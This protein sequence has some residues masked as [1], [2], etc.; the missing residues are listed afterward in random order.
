MSKP[1]FV[2]TSYIRSTPEQV[3]KGLTSPEFQKQYW[4]L[5]LETDWV[6]GSEVVWVWDDARV[7]SPTQRV[8]ECDPYSRLSYS[9]H[10]IDEQ[11]D[12][13]MFTAEEREHMSTE[14]ASRATF[15]L[16]PQSNG[17][18]KLT[19]T[20]DEFDDDSIMATKV[21]GGW[22]AVLSSLKSFLE[23]GTGL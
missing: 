3:W 8:L 5:A 13:T 14:K 10:V 12:W 9:W 18:V 16:E 11:R 19:L 23:T 17:T 22:P 1:E 20:H 21:S 15:T 7:S 6:V 2:Y 4:G